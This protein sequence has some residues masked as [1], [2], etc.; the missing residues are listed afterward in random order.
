M[1]RSMTKAEAK[2]FVRRWQ[3]ANAAEANELRAATP[4][5]KL[6]QLAALMAS[7]DRFGWRELL[8]EGE[9]QVRAR[10]QRLRSLHGK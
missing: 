2:A 9:D 10:W 3:Q 7:V 1:K 5:L 6:Q 8:A 4:E